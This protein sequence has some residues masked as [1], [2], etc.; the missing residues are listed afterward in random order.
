MLSERSVM[1]PGAT[2]LTMLY[3]IWGEWPDDY[4]W[5]E[6]KRERGRERVEDLEYIDRI[7]EEYWE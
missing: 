5:R 2:R 3:D 1:F 6:I 4:V 7:V